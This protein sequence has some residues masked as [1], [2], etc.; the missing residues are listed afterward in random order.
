M[1]GD[2]GQMEDECSDDYLAQLSEDDD[3]TSQQPSKKRKVI[4]SSIAHKGFLN[5]LHFGILDKCNWGILD[6][7]NCEEIHTIIQ[8]SMR[9]IYMYLVLVAG[10]L[11]K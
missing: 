4:Y 3:E 7:C 11:L 6:K 9:Y 1:S 2:L 8:D 5:F 10:K